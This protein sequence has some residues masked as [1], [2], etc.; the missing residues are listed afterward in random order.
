MKVRDLR[1]MLA[2]RRD[3]EDLY[4]KS[5]YWDSK[6]AEY[7]DAAVSMWPNN[8]LNIHYQREQ[9]AWLDRYTSDLSGKRIL[10]AGCGVGRLSKHYAARGARV[11]GI[12]FSERSVELARKG[13][14]GDNPQFRVQSLFDLAD[15]AQ[16]DIVIVWGVLTVACRNRAELLD[17]LTRLRIALVPGG[18]LLMME[19]I[20]S[21]FL[22]RVLKLGMKEVTAVLGEAG[23]RIHDVTHLYF[24]PTRLALAYIQWPKLLTDAGYYIGSAF[25]SLLGRKALGDYKAIFATTPGAAAGEAIKSDTQAA[26]QRTPGRL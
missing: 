21:G 13:V 11:V 22:H 20:H 15:R 17:A 16:Y 10:D 5:E 25:F 3:R 26:D 2:N 1:A 7:S 24:W 18:S 14:Q 23:F 12:D 19:P 6:A 9:F 8:H 4:C